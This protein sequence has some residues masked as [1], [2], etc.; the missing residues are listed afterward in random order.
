MEHVFAWLG[1]IFQRLIDLIPRLIVINSI[2]G[3]VAWVRGKPRPIRPGRLFLYWPFWTEIC[4]LPVN[5]QTIDLRAQ[6]YCTADDVPFLASGIVVYEIR[7]AMK[8]A[9]AAHD[10][11]EAIRD[12]SMAALIRQ[13][14]AKSWKD[15][16]EQRLTI[17]ESIRGELRR[18]LRDWGVDIRC[19][20][21]SDLAPCTV[22]HWSG[23]AAPTQ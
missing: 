20:F 2:E 4:I 9:L 11:D 23:K 14:R 13:L 5:R 15:V 19:F 18:L 21:L 3:G 10:L 8:A 17:D 12:L 22:L 1:D 7:D 6:A 16:Y